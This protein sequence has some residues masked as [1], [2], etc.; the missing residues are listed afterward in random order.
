MTDDNGTRS[1]SHDPALGD[2]FTER[3]CI[4]AYIR[5]TV[6]RGQPSVPLAVFLQAVAGSESTAAVDADEIIPLLTEGSTDVQDTHRAEYGTKQADSS[7]STRTEVMMPG[8]TTLALSEL[9]SDLDQQA[10]QIEHQQERLREQ[11]E[12]IEALRE[13]LEA[14][15]RHLTNNDPEY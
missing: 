1:G 4:E 11:R 12:D 6:G 14:I 8:G 10:T 13:K 9:R 3:Q 15:D 5:A 2:Q 7:R